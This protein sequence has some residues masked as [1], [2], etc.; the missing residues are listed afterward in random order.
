MAYEATSFSFLET[1]LK[2]EKDEITLPQRLQLAH[3]PTPIQS[4]PFLSQELGKEIFIKRDDL[5]G[6]GVSG[7]KIRKLE[8][9]MAEARE[10]GCDAVIT[11]GGI[12]S[13]HARATALIARRLGLQPILLLRGEEPDS[14]QGNLLINKMCSALVHWISP[15]DWPN[16]P[17]VMK[18]IHDAYAEQGWSPII[19]P[20]GGSNELGS[21]AYILCEKEIQEFEKHQQKTFDSVFC[22]T[23]SG[24]TYAGLLLGKYLLNA[25]ETDFYT[26]NVCDSDEYFE[27]RV[28]SLMIDSIRKHELP[29]SFIPEDIRI[30]DGFVGPGYG[31]ASEP[32]LDL[33]LEM[34]RMEGFLFDPVYTGKALFGMKEALK[35]APDVF[36][37]RI[38]FIHTGGVFANFDQA[39]LLE[40]KIRNQ[41]ERWWN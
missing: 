11:C 8:F 39:S 38:L 23:G 19:I 9:L 6:F 32:Q 26:I 17:T 29:I 20:E 21:L 40:Q 2:R 31:E 12:Q 13:N 25:D 33:I 22:A 24:G 4:L 3:L 36:G 7:N 18:E 37:D 35:K 15:N 30:I 1:K 27:N 41:E 16:H 14:Y 28:K 34:A 5:T 10:K